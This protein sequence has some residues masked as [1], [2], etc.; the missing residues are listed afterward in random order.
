MQ[1]MLDVCGDFANRH[2]ITFSTDPNPARSKSKCMFITGSKRNL[3][4]PVTL[5]LGKNELPW[6]TNAMHLGHELDI[7]GSMEHDAK[8]KRAEFIQKSTEI[9]ETFS[10][11]SPVEVLRALKIYCSS[12]Y[13]AMLWNFCGQNA[14]QLFN[15]WNTAIKLSWSCPRDTRS[16]LVQ[17]VLSCG[18]DSAKSDIITRYGKF[19]EV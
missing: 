9:R 13:G 5:C 7:S 18:L 6:V 10:F 1:Q 2:N 19:F 17:E 8:V 16:Y 11:A 4:N 15:S 14:E 3:S 12:F